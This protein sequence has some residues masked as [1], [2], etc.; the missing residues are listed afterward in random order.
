ME[1]RK[2]LPYLI[3]R[4]LAPKSTPCSKSLQIADKAPCSIACRAV[5]RDREDGC[6]GVSPG[7][8][9]LYAESSRSKKER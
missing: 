9:C 4:A 5:V 7:T 1:R 2:R 8:A 6:L 3:Q